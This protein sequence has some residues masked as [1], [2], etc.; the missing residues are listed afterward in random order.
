MEDFGVSKSI[1]ISNIPQ[2]LMEKYDLI[3]KRLAGSR[4][5]M[6]KLQME[7]LVRNCQSFIA[8]EATIAQ[9]VQHSNDDV[10]R[11]YGM[12]VPKSKEITQ[13]HLNLN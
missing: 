13:Q 2:G 6:M 11:F 4:S 8:H 1:T 10:W 12:D 3:A 7:N 9:M 5:L